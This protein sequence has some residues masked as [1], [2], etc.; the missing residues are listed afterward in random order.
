MMQRNSHGVK[1]VM[2]KTFVQ[3]EKYAET[4]QVKKRLEILQNMAL[5]LHSALGLQPEIQLQRAS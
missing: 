1:A 5:S 2:T 3:K 4:V